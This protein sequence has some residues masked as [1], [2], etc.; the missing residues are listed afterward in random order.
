MNQQTEQE[1]KEQEDERR[2]REE[3]EWKRRR[4]QYYRTLND[5]EYRW[6]VM[7]N[8]NPK[9]VDFQLKRENALRRQAGGARFFQ[10]EYFIPFCF[11]P[12]TSEKENEKQVKAVEEANSLREDF[13]DFVFI[14]TTRRGIAKLLD[15]EWNR[16]MRSRLYHYRDLH[17][18]AVTI[19]D[20]EMN[21]LISAFSERR[22]RFSIG[23]PVVNIGPDVEVQIIKDGKFK[24]QT[25]RVIKVRPTT[26]G[27][28]LLELGVKMFNGRKEL[29]LHDMTTDDVQSKESAKELVGSR[30]IRETEASLVGIISRRVNHKET[31]DS[32]KEDVV[33]LNHL[34]LYSYLSVGDAALNARFLS[35]ML[36]CATLRYDKESAK[37]LSR[38][39]EEILQKESIPQEHNGLTP[40]ILAYLNFS[41][42]IATRD[43]R[44][45]TAGKQCVQQHPDEC[46]SESLHRLMA[47]AGRMHSKR[48]RTRQS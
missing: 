31:D 37:A 30:F 43:A 42:Y 21:K 8:A 38:Q 22:I 25:A 11:L 6:Y 18:K 14:Y 45:R 24:G 44:Y 27:I 1:K 15:R 39:A 5:T 36:I 46:V 33:T 20:E 13:H 26:N 23:I 40:D 35:L 29:K 48:D 4:K 2:E 47:L 16:S 12:H 3:K 7:Q 34:F 17:R 10:L 32:Q 28:F 19:S 41:L 9:L